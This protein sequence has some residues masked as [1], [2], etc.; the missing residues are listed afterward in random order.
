MRLSS[1]HLSSRSRS[2]VACA[3]RGW[4]SAPAGWSRRDDRRLE[5]HGQASLLNYARHAHL[6][7]HASVE[8]EHV[9]PSARLAPFSADL[10]VGAER[11]FDAPKRARARGHATAKNL[12]LR[13]RAHN[14]LAAELDF[15]R[16]FM[17]DRIAQRDP[18]RR[19]NGSDDDR[20]HCGASDDDSTT[21]LAR[22]TVA[23]LARTALARVTVA[24]R[25]AL[26][27]PHQ[28]TVPRSLS[29]D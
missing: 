12:T 19:G 18:R 21:A 6:D 15:G 23:T 28:L 22:V 16:D 26:V 7:R 10:F 13:S 8:A 25:T 3:A 5:A 14:T 20:A 17:A 29:P 2:I 4:C 1:A 9:P 11:A 24:V 27:R